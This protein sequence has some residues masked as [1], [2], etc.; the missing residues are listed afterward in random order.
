MITNLKDFQP[1]ICT[2]VTGETLGEF[3]DNLKRIQTIS[4]LI[5]LRVDY[6]ENFDIK[7]LEVISNE[8]IKNKTLNKK[9]IFTL[10]SNKEG[11]KY[12]GDEHKRLELI[13][14]AYENQFDYIDL[15]LFACE[16]FNFDKYKGSKTIVSFHDFNRT[17]EFDELNEVEKQ[18]ENTSADIIKIAT[19]AKIKMM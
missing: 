11:G 16:Q 5:E 12:K 8:T 4:D 9:Y 15:E 2:V 13:Q 14:T 1:R 3:L 18:I 19:F 17:P 10:R 6:I 7:A